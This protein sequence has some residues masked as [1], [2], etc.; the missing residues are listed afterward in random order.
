MDNAE[1]LYNENKLLVRA[2]DWPGLSRGMD[3]LYYDCTTW[4]NEFCLLMNGNLSSA[5]S[6]L[7][8]PNV[9]VSTYK[10]IGFLVNSDLANCFHISKSDSGSNGN[11]DN[12]DFFA[13]SPDFLTVKEL[14][15][16]IKDNNDI[17]MNEVNIITSIDSVVGLFINECPEQD[18]LLQMIYL[19]KQCLLKLTEIDYPIYLYSRKEGKLKEIELSLEKEQQIINTLLTSQIFYWPDE[20]SEPIID[21]I[22]NIKSNIK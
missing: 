20:Y 6:T 16:H 12:G 15:N 14:A 7:I 11:I 10:N 3:G 21:D 22:N 5:S 2:M 1:T 8:I 17:S 4:A 19:V 18:R 13:N 9:G